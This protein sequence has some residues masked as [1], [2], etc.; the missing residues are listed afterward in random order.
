MNPTL[1]AHLRELYQT[2][3]YTDAIPLLLLELSHSD[4]SECWNDWAALQFQLNQKE[5][6]EAGFRIALEKDPGNLQSA[7]NLGALLLSDGHH[8]EAEPLLRQVATSG[9][10][11]YGEPANQL[12]GTLREAGSL[13]SSEIGRYLR[14]F[15]SKS[16]NEQSYFETHLK[17]YVAT[18]QMLPM[19]TAGSRLLELGAA[20]HHLTPALAQLRNYEVVRCNDVWTGEPRRTRQVCSIDGQER[21]SFE[22]DNF[23]VQQGPWPYADQDFD[24]VLSCEMLEHLHTDPMCLFSEI[25]RILKPQGVL[26]LTTPN[27]AGGHALEFALRGESPYVYGKFERNGAPTDRHN[28]EYTANEVQSLAESAGFECIHLRTMNSWWSYPSQVARNLVLQGYPIARRGD[29]TF[30]LARKHVGVRDRYPVNFYQSIGTQSPRRADQATESLSRI[31]APAHRNIL[32]IHEVLPH[33]DCSGADLRLLDVIRELLA[34]GHH[35]TYFARSGKNASRYQPELEGLGITVL[36]DGTQNSEAQDPETGPHDLLSSTLRQQTFDIAMFFHWFWAR[37]S[38]T[39]EYLATVRELSPATRILVLSDDR[40]GERERRA[41]QL[42]GKF[43]DFERGNSFEDREREAYTC[44]DLVLYIAQSDKDWFMRLVPGLEA[45]YLPL[46]ADVPADVN[47]I[48]NRSGALFL[49]NFENPAN[50]DALRWMISEVWPVVQAEE[51]NLVLHVAGHGITDDMVRGHKNVVSLGKVDDLGGLFDS[52]RLFVSP[53]RYGTGINTK[54]LQAL[55]RGVPLVATSVSAE[56]LQ[57]H[58]ERDALIADSPSDFAADIV[59][60]NRDDA[61]WTALSK[62][63]REFAQQNFSRA[64][65]REELRKIIDRAM[66]IEPKSTRLPVWSYRQIERP[67]G[68]AVDRALPQYRSMLRV[69]SYWVLGRKYMDE[70]QFKNALQQLRHVFTLHRGTV[71]KTVFDRAVLHD[72]TRCYASLGDAQGQERCESAQRHSG[73]SHIQAISPVASR[74]RRRKRRSISVVFPTFN[75]SHLL[76]TTLAAWAFQTLAVDH[77]E[78]I[79]VDDGSNDDTEE[80]CQGIQLP[81][82]LRYMRQEN[83]GAGAARR[84]GVEAAGGEILLLCNDDTIPDSRLLDEHLRVHGAPENRNNAVLGR[85]TASRESARKALSFFVNRSA[86][87]FPQT[88]LQA[89]QLLDQA[90]FIT[91][92]LSIRR[93]LVLAG[94]NFDPQFRVAEDTE[95]GTRL[96][97]RGSRVLYHPDATAD[98]EH[99]TFT[100]EDLIRRAKAYGRADWT[101]FSKHP[102]LLGNGSSPFGLLTESDIHSIARRLDEGR[103]AVRAAVNA[104]HALDGLDFLPCLDPC[105]RNRQSAFDILKQLAKLVPL[106]YWHYLLESFLER[107]SE[108]KTTTSQNRYDQSVHTSCHP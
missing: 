41:A 18:L 78:L 62:T 68:T 1:R 101:L 98:H 95:L 55:S 53:V 23:D 105:N 64:L 22:V 24:A 93:D 80:L 90:Y 70:G 56:G 77:W 67:S 71:P 51:P 52:R 47:G 26:L 38:V 3:R 108:E 63:G 69:L 34:E 104:L 102:R 81:Y 13:P 73:G 42:S 27:I 58:D 100:T 86:F 4:T 31:A 74:G 16:E 72:M 12:L 88:T 59:R 46:A 6:A 60:L 29:N 25:N 11:E 99:G 91:C 7:L 32:L 65:L 28:R 83:L 75:R 97:Q 76:R 82:R 43:A 79:V 66:K 5:E 20:F 44:A 57:L 89:G 21:F 85:F 19:G 50:S 84:A 9:A 61:L 39:E 87:F 94:G 36:V 45:M 96:V 15:V 8:H 40:H 10:P 37:M 30:L 2:R 33:H 106:V 17:R 14:R 54:N 92:N 103:D 48:G 49:G 35:I 107:R